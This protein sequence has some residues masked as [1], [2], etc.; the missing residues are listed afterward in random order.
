MKSNREEA[1]NDIDGLM[2]PK[3]MANLGEEWGSG[4][5]N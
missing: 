5:N 3:D 4:D 1:A 2:D